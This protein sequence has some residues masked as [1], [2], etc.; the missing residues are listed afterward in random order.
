MQIALGKDEESSYKPNL[1]LLT[2]Y[3]RGETGILFTNKS[4]AKI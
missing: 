1:Y 2:K 3:L 4:A